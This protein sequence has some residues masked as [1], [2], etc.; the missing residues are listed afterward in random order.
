MTR[1]YLDMDPQFLRLLAVAILKDVL[2]A[3]S[4]SGFQRV[5]V[6]LGRRAKIFLGTGEM[7]VGDHVW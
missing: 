6:G 3:L 4:T 1:K 2:R 7:R 5:L